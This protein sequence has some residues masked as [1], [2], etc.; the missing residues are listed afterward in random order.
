A[1]P[2]RPLRYLSA[3]EFSAPNTSFY[4]IPVRLKP[5]T[6]VTPSRFALRRTRKSHTTV[7]AEGNYLRGLTETATCT[8]VQQHWKPPPPS[9]DASFACR[10]STYSPGALKV[11]VAAV[12]PLL[13]R[14]TLGFGLSNVTA[15]GPRNIDQVA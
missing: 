13:A 15:A 7:T 5:D 3:E 6:T 2:L 1:P 9:P 11:A 10:R 14:S 8:L 12:L 4:L